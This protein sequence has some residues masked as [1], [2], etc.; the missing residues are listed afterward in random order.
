MKKFNLL[1]LLILSV[2]FSMNAQITK[3]SIPTELSS[4][5]FYVVK[6]FTLGSA[7][8][9]NNGSFTDGDLIEKYFTLKN[10]SVTE[11]G[12][13]TFYNLDYSI[14]KSLNLIIPTGYPRIDGITFATTHLFNTDDLIEFVVG[15]RTAAYA[16][17][18]ILMNENGDV[19]FDFKNDQPSNVF[20]GNNGELKLYTSHYAATG[21]SVYT[22]Q[23]PKINQ[24]SASNIKSSIAPFPNPAKQIIHLPYQL[25]LGSRATMKI[26]DVKGKQIT[27]KQIDATFDKLLLDVSAYQKGMYVYEYNGKSGKFV[28]E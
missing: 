12:S 13:I 14:Y 8:Y 6:E 17:S 21:C 4:E 16:T 19:I 10:G 7:T 20:T 5:S 27:T 2:V 22:L 26:F 9:F 23:S 1:T 28:V 11:T 18:Y 24:L 25:E 15:F 3:D